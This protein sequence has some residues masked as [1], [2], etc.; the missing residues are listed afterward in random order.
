MLIDYTVHEFYQPA[1]KDPSYVIPDEFKKRFYDYQNDAER[2]YSLCTA[3]ILKPEEDIAYADK[4]ATGI[5]SKG[6][7][8]LFTDNIVNILSEN[9]PFTY[10]QIMLTLVSALDLEKLEDI[11]LK[12]SESI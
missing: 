10:Y 6:T 9:N 4:V 5:K 1:V 2:E 7:I 3:F 8:N 12:A 11:A